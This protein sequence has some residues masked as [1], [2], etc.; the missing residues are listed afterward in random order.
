MEVIEVLGNGIGMECSECGIQG[1]YSGDRFVCPG[2]GYEADRKANAA[3]NA[4]RRG[5]NGQRINAEYPAEE[6]PVQTVQS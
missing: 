6:N 1:K 5:K 4:V 3:R 2:C